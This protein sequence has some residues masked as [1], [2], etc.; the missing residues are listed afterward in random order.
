MDKKS[1]MQNR[2]GVEM[3]QL[4]TIEEQQAMKERRSGQAKTM[5]NEGGE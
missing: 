2:I 4:E 1:D 3:I 5:P